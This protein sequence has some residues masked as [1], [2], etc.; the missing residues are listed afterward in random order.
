M[1]EVRTVHAKYIFLDVVNYT[2]DRTV[3]AQS[4]IIRVLNEIVIEGLAFYD[5]TSEN[6]ILLPTGD[7]ICIAIIN[8]SEPYDVHLALA[9][10]I[11]SGIDKHNSKTEDVMR[12]FKIRI[13]INENIDNLITDINNNRNIAG[14]GINAAQRV[15][16]IADDNQ[17]LVSQTVYEKLYQ[18]EKYWK[19]FTPFTVTVKHN[20]KMLVY[21]YINQHEGLAINP[22]AEVSYSNSENKFIKALQNFFK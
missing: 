15:M 1:S 12:K 10:R 20:L 4:H 14:A 19:K 18:R 13:G 3:E 22:P 16:S 21:Q 6:L 8:V 2:Q 5:L 7:G 9:L 17:I 11:L